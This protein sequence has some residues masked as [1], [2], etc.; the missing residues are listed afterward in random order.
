MEFVSQVVGVYERPPPTP[1]GYKDPVMVHAAGKFHGYVIG[2]I[3][4]TERVYHFCSDDGEH[5]EPVGD[6]SRSIMDLTAWH[7]FAVRPASVLPIGAGYLFIYDGSSTTWPDPVYNI[8][9]G[10]GFTFDLHHVRDLTPDAPLLVSP[11]PGRLHTW[12]YSH[13]MWVGNEVWV[14]A[15]V[16]KPNSAH[17][18]RRFRLPR[19]DGTAKE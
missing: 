2:T 5:W 6:R 16:E 19:D 15:E 3:R 1:D 10:M 8:G 18:I 4:S 14:Y 11:T 12:R 7:D 13:W 17:E 9:T